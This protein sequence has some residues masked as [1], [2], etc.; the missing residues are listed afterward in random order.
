MD[1]P[2]KAVPRDADSKQEPGP[3]AENEIGPGNSGRSRAKMKAAERGSGHYYRD[4]PKE[5]GNRK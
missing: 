2:K 4:G 1:P 5:I 3:M